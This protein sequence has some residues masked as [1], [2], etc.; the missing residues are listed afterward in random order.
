MD[1]INVMTYDL[2]G[3]W[4][5]TTGFNSPLYGRPEDTEDGATLNADWVAKYWQQL[6]APSH[7]INLGHKLFPGSP[8]TGS[9][10]GPAIKSI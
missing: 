5:S 6:G 4:E 7:K 2:H 3:A 9:D 10:E 8:N 1:F